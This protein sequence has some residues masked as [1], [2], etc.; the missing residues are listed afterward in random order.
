MLG[1]Q[2]KSQ[3]TSI[4]MMSARWSYMSLHYYLVHYYITGISQQSGLL[5]VADTSCVWCRH[6]SL[7]FEIFSPPSP[8]GGNARS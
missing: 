4:I 7:T 3:D 2:P 8:N 1:F 5:R 6:S